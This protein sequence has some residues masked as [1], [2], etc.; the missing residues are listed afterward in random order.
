MAATNRILLALKE[1]EEFRE[2]LSM[3]IANSSIIVL[4]PNS[5]VR[6]PFLIL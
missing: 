2:L 6:L 3:I 4:P 1:K 5:S